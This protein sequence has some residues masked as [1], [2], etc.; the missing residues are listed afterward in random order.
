[1]GVYD[2][3]NPKRLFGQ[4]FP[5]YVGAVAPTQLDSVMLWLRQNSGKLMTLVKVAIQI[6]SDI[7]KSVKVKVRDGQF[8][9]R[10]DWNLG[11]AEPGT[12][13]QCLTC[14]TVQDVHI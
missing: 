4:F 1:M 10:E 7:I 3:S 14:D 9:L 12:A 2:E 6:W 5:I 13:T 8:V 11:S